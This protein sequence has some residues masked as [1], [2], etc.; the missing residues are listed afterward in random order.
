MKTHINFELSEELVV[1][2]LLYR[3]NRKFDVVVNVRRASVT[4]DGGYYG[5][6][7]EGDEDEINRVVAFLEELGADVIEG[8]GEEA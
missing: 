4:E 5:L 2:P 8:L 1:T 3:L 7:L 6:E